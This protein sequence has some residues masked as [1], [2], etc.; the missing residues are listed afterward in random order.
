[1]L[2]VWSDQN[3]L[4]APVWGIEWTEVGADIPVPPG[5]SAGIDRI[6]AGEGGA[7]M[8]GG[9]NAGITELN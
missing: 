8:G 7:Y 2:I 3:V 9:L 1:M 6:R 5:G 4:G